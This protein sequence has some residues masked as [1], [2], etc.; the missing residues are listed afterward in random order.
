MLPFLHGV[1]FCGISSELVDTEEQK[2]GE[3][4][5]RVQKF[6]LDVHHK[7]ILYSIRFG[8]VFNHI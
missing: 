5:N 7:V 1:D 3:W 6:T 4:F 8:C 2:G